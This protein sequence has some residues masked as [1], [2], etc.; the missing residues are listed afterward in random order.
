MVKESDIK[1]EV[2]GFEF[3]LTS[4]KELGTCRPVGM[5]VGPI[6]FTSIAEYARIFEVEGEDFFELLYYVR[7]MDDEYLKLEKEKSDSENNKAKSKA[8]AKGKK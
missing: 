1:P 3:Y 6:P 4:F 2:S 8:K 5:G 7:E